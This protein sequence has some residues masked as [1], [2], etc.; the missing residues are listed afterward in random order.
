[1]VV[2]FAQFHDRGTPGED[3]FADYR[4]G[5][6]FVGIFQLRCV[7]NRVGRSNEGEEDDDEDEES[8]RGTKGGVDGCSFELG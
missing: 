8:E 3:A 1:M 5:M 6:F 7:D 2:I 4:R